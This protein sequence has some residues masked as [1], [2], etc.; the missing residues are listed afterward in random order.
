MANGHRQLSLY[1]RYASLLQRLCSVHYN[2]SLSATYDSPDDED[3][4]LLKRDG[5]PL[6][7]AK[8]L[9]SDRCAWDG[10]IKATVTLASLRLSAE[11][12]RPLLP[13]LAG[14][15]SP[16]NV[17]AEAILHSH[18]GDF[19][20][21]ITLFDP[22]AWQRGSRLIGDSGFHAMTKI[23]EKGTESLTVSLPAGVVAGAMKINMTVA[24]QEG[25]HPERRLPMRHDQLERFAKVLRRLSLGE[26][27]V[28]VTALPPRQ[29]QTSPIEAGAGT[30]PPWQGDISIMIRH[31]DI[32]VSPAYI[33]SL[34]PL[35][36][37]S[38]DYVDLLA[39]AVL[40][41]R[42]NDFEEYS[43]LVAPED[44]D[45]TVKGWIP[46]HWGLSLYPPEGEEPHR[47]QFRGHVTRVY[48]ALNS[49]MLEAATEGA[50]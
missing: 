37:E 8:G 28:L 17:L 50:K 42:L 44:W 29:E 6:E 24:A 15:R 45:R 14:Q 13:M 12:I 35:M 20:K 34:L 5:V 18:F 31:R 10:R 11:Y 46:R 49:Q 25:E 48:Q 36:R 22:L 43:T 1:E 9:I 23:A 41:A 19:Q 30:Q 16:T 7:K 27:P 21:Y 47:F 26:Y 4:R 33:R 39:E 2:L 3:K 40:A 32:G 38:Q